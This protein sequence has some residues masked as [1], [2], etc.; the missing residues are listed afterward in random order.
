[1]S[2]GAYGME[3]GSDPAADSALSYAYNNG[4]VLFAS[5]G[6]Y[7][8]P[9]IAYPAK[10][11]AVIAVGAASPSGEKLSILPMVNVVGFRLLFAGTGY[12]RSG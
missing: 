11:P 5:T 1:M 7:D 3:I 4:V 9:A 2:F 8:E 6:N 10:H 12:S